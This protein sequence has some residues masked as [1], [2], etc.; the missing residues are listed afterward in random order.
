MHGNRFLLARIL[1]EEEKEKVKEEKKEKETAVGIAP[2]LRV[3]SR[4][5]GLRKAGP[6]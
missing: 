4:G 3:P 5:S 1:L 6:A 2:R